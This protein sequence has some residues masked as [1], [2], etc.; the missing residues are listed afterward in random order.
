MRSETFWGRIYGGRG[1]NWEGR[2]PYGSQMAVEIGVGFRWSPR[3]LNRQ[4]FLCGG[5]VL[6]RSFFP[7]KSSVGVGV[8]NGSRRAWTLL[9]RWLILLFLSLQGRLPG[10]GGPGRRVLCWR[11]HTVLGAEPLGLYIPMDLRV[12]LL[13]QEFLFI[14]RKA[15]EL[16]K[17]DAV[18]Q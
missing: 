16:N 6:S 4:F 14:F 5:L 15:L 9:G 13:F 8:L 12:G 7:P 1:R 2:I 17:I 11:E 18:V 3:C 10:N